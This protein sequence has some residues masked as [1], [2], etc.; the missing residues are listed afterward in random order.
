VRQPVV[1][2]MIN[3]SVSQVETKHYCKP[4][5]NKRDRIVPAPPWKCNS[6]LSAL[7][8]V[9]L[10]HPR[11]FAATLLNFL[12][13]CNISKSIPPHQFLI[14]FATVF[15]PRPPSAERPLCVI[16][17]ILT[18]TAIVVV[19]RLNAKR[20]PRLPENDRR[21]GPYRSHTSDGLRAR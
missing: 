17:P 6:E 7:L 11:P 14:P 4:L 19:L 2:E 12:F 5:V 18:A 8:D 1:F 13:Q 21:R 3:A 15:L 9:L 16:S 20:V 10:S